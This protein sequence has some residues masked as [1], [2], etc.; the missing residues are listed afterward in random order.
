[1][2][3]LL[4]HLRRELEH[5]MLL[6]RDLGPFRESSDEWGAHSLVFANTDARI[7]VASAE[8]SV[9]GMRH[10]EHRP[11][12]IV[13]DD[14]EDITSTKTREGRNKTYQWLRGDIIPAGDRSTRLIVVGNLLHEDSLLMRLKEDVENDKTDGCFL[15]F[16]IVDEQGR[17]LWPGKYPTEADIEIERRKIGND[18][19]WRREFLLEIV[20]DDEQVIYKEWIK[21]FEE[22]PNPDQITSVRVSVDPAISKKS[23]A[24]YTGILTG[25]TAKY[26]GEIVL[27]ILP[28]VINDRLNFPE[29]VQRCQELN[30]HLVSAYPRVYPRFYVEDVGYQRSLIQVLQ[31]EGLVVE[32][33]PSTTDKRSRL[34]LTGNAIQTGKVLF[35]E[36]G[37]ERVVE[38]I[39]HFGVEKYDDLADAF[40]SL[41]LS[42]VHN[43]V[44]FIGFV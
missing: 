7:T 1:V 5:N 27:Y 9:R 6:K 12:L 11:D 21:Y 2:E 4:Q 17:C 14:V 43:P 8:Q 26:G 31:D 30:R 44:P 29:T 33:V 34:A 13:C 37:C 41:V 35:P 39:V 19:A 24:D 16:P 23:S 22:L 25:L 15:S 40:S 32:S 36:N 42:T 3:E 28:N 10:H 38:Q 20:P 18:I